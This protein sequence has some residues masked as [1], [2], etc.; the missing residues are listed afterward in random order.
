M[1]REH[2]ERRNVKIFVHTSRSGIDSISFPSRHPESL[3][4]TVTF[5]Q[6]GNLDKFENYES[7]CWKDLRLTSYILPISLPCICIAFSSR[8][9]SII[10]TRSP[11]YSLI[12]TFHPSQFSRQTTPFGIITL[13]Q[14]VEIMIAREI[15]SAF[16]GT[17]LVQLCA[18]HICMF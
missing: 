11:N 9:L 5:G 14:S 18:K 3:Y 4:F 1:S 12:R 13:A 7:N 17:Y 8:E 10:Q 6:E 15:H 2:I 16:N